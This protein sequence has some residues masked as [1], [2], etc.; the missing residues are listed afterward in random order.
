MARICSA[1]R[2]Y[3]PTCKPCNATIRDLLPGSDQAHARALAAGSHVC[4]KCEFDYFKTI[5]FC[6]KCG[7]ERDIE[8][9]VLG[10]EL[11]ELIHL[12]ELLE[13]IDEPHRSD[14]IRFM[15]KNRGLFCTSK[16]SATKHQ[17]WPGGYHDH[18]SEVMRIALATYTIFE[19]IRPLP[20]TLSDALF[21]CFL[22]D[23]EKIWKHA[24]VP[25]E[26]LKVDKWKILEDEFQLNDDHVNAIKYAH[27]EGD[28]Y[29]PT[30]RIQGP[31]AAFVHHCDNTSARIWFDSPEPHER[32]LSPEQE[33]TRLV[34]D[35]CPDKIDEQ[36]AKRMLVLEDIVYTDAN[37][38]TL[39]PDEFRTAR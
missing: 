18:V 22:H 32:F 26:K 17:P 25:A 7:M 34:R 29:H 1:H 9:R 24:L 12:P 27:G 30:D 15:D 19:T 4:E 2:G 5:D 23:V 3:E 36:V 28:D 20:F 33:Y 35:Y 31:L 6:P 13:M 10:P 37:R 11:G 14:C 21:C 8:M 16:G 38:Q 39:V